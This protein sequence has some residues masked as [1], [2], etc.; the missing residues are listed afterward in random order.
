MKVSNTYKLENWLLQR[1]DKAM[2]ITDETVSS[3]VVRAEGQSENFFEELKNLFKKINSM[4]SEEATTTLQ[5][6]GIIRELTTDKQK[7]NVTNQ[8][9]R[10]VGARMVALHNGLDMFDPQQGKQ[11]N[12][13]K[14][15]LQTFKF[16][17]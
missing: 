4:G 16:I 13:L 8:L 1:K 9:M 14:A 3:L 12:Q 15:V 7:W 2:H 6:L 11:R 17:T 5:T 10:A